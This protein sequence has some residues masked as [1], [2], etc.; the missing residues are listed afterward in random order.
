MRPFNNRK[1]FLLI[2]LAVIAFVALIGFV[3][4]TLWNNLLPDILHVGTITY[5]Q[6]LG[7]F[8]LCKILFGFGKGGRGFRGGGA[9]WM[10]GKWEDRFKNMSPEEREHFKNKIRNRCGD[11]RG[12]ED[13]KWDSFKT[14]AEVEKTAE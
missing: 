4:M 7:I 2:P 10:R 6:A 9:P 14:E 3:V 8:V 5:W 11:R 13:Y 1:K 12:W